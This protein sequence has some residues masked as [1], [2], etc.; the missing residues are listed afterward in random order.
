M[1]NRLFSAVIASII[2]MGCDSKP[3]GTGQENKD[4]VVVYDTMT[5]K[6]AAEKQAARPQPATTEEI[7]K[8]KE[9]PVLCYHQ[10][11]EWRA[12]DSKTAKEIIVPVQL[13]KDQIKML[14]D[15]GYN[16]IL[17]EEYYN[18]LVNGTK[19]PENPVMITFDDSDGE[20][21]TIGNEVLKQYGYKGV[22]F[23]M[24][25]S[26]N[27]PRYMTKEQV[28][29]LSDEGNCIAIH[30][31]NHQN[32]PSYKTEA[33][34]NLQVAQPKK[35]LEAL[36]GKKI[37]FFAYPYGLWNKEAFEPLKQHG[38]KA[39]FILATKKDPTEPLFTLR[40]IIASA[41]WSP[42]ALNRSM[43]LSFH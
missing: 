42:A 5:S 24:T 6:E 31:W 8:K 9:V 28:K 11:R 23:L 4:A 39:A 19:L 16:T 15:S 10:I 3:G 27:R 38:V 20:Q 25:V 2:L 21:F 22:Y 36:T 7:L 17:P 43:K 26:L 30:T 41:F 34:W 40:R 32:V 12:S 1:Y 14:H 37:E 33:D 35:M 29:Q 13:F 18:Y